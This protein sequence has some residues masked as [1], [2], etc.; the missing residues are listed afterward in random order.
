M[1]QSEIYATNGFQLALGQTRDQDGVRGWKIHQQSTENDNKTD[2][3]IK[4][5]LTID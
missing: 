4:K 2:N 1:M 5:P 3:Q